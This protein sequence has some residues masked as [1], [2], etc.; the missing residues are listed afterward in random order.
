MIQFKRQMM[1]TTIKL[2]LFKMLRGQE[3]REKSR[4]T[5][6]AGE[7]EGYKSIKYILLITQIAKTKI[8]NPFSC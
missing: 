1:I 8:T 2:I 7:K 3:R 5:M 6:I 4:L